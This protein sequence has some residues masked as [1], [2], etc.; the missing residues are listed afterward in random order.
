MCGGF[1]SLD[2]QTSLKGFVTQFISICNYLKNELH[3]NLTVR[4]TMK[5]SLSVQCQINMNLVFH[6]SEDGSGIE[7][8]L[9]PSDNVIYFK[10]PKS[11]CVNGL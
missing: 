11:C 8:Q 6:I 5:N 10:C 1:F 4:R 7:F 3:I 9:F 2:I